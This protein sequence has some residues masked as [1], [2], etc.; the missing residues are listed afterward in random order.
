MLRIARLSAP[1]FHLQAVC[2]LTH[3]SLRALHTEFLHYTVY[4]DVIS[5]TVYVPS[6]HLPANRTP[7]GVCVCVSFTCVLPRVCCC[8]LSR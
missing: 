2:S 3:T 7:C 1:S 6:L 8:L 5:C 4:A